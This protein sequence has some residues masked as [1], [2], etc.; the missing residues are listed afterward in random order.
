MHNDESSFLLILRQT[1]DESPRH[2]LSDYNTTS[3]LFDA[4]QRRCDRSGRLNKLEIITQFFH[5]LNSTE[6]RDT[7]SWLRSLQ[8]IYAKF[9]SWKMS[10]SEFFGLLAQANI[11]IPETL[12][13]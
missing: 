7:G 13:I 1:I 12:N 9:M 10:F 3:S 2:L 4:L 8:D 11:Q 5:I 6:H